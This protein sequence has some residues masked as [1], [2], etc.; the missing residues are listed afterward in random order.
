MLIFK[1]DFL[2]IY[3]ESVFEFLITFVILLEERNSKF[4]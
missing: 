2:N 3:K 1:Y 4:K